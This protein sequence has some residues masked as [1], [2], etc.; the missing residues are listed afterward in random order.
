MAGVSP[1]MKLWLPEFAGILASASCLVAIA[2]LLAACDG[3]PRFEWHS[4]TLNA[5]VSIL[6]TTSKASLLFAIAELISQ[7]K[8]IVFAKG[9][10]PL[11]DLETIDGASRGPYG[12]L[13]VMWKCKQMYVIL[14]TF[15]I[16]T[17]SPSLN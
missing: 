5:V 11:V 12:S 8:W 2:C 6:S 7:W 17:G 13:E 14:E 16:H 15:P 10:R 9:R 4:V 1:S 3:K